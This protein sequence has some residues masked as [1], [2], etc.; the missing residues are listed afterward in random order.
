MRSAGI[1][2]SRSSAD[3]TYC[4]GP[5]RRFFAHSISA[6]RS[7]AGRNLYGA[8]KRLPIWRSRSAFDGRMRPSRSGA[9]W[10]SCL[11]A[12][13]WKVPARTRVTPRAARRARNS[14]PALSVNVTA[15]ICAGSNAPDATCCAM[16]RV[17][18]VVLPV[19]A[20]ARMQTG[21]RT[22]SAARRALGAWRDVKDARRDVVRRLDDLSA[23]VEATAERVAA[24]GDTAELQ[25][26]VARLRVS[27]A[28]L[29]V[30]RAAVDEAHDDTV[31][32]VTAYL[33]R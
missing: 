7:P 31:G 33:P 20:P 26:S 12:A 1:G 15:M 2:G 30:L 32:R 24:A 27:L 19:P 10:R 18:V 23:N 11:S 6:A 21:P 29:A 16:R 9:K 5:M 8:R 17:I 14:P 13:E 22:A 28:Q 3:S 25:E 4:S